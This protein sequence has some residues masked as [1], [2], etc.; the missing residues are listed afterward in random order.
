M[1][2]NHGSERGIIDFRAVQG[3]ESLL[4]DN[5]RNKS[6]VSL[7]PGGKGVVIVDPALQNDVVAEY[8]HSR[9]R[10]FGWLLGWASSEMRPTLHV[11]RL[12]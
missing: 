5:S 4:V 8:K 11:F 3:S 10:G 1:I 6:S 7:A 12:V 9:R 2:G